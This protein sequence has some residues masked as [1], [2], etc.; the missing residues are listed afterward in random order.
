MVR[1]EQLKKSL[2]EGAKVT[3]KHIVQYL[4]QLRTAISL[5]VL[6]L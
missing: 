3:E 6:N 4:Y 2:H 1:E 5:D